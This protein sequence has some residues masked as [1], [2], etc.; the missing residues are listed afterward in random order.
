MDMGTLAALLLC[1][2]ITVS[3]GWEATFY[4][5]GFVGIVWAALF[6]VLTSATPEDN[7]FITKYEQNYI[8]QCI[9]EERNSTE[10]DKNQENQN[11]F[12][13]LWQVFK[14]PGTMYHVTNYC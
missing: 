8:A 9:E 2:L 3:M 7:N 4:I 10:A 6:L 12:K 11:V 13:F 5:F 1:P 14:S